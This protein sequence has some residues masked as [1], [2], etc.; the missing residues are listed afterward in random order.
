MGL[1]PLSKVKSA[2]EIVGIGEN[3][4]ALPGWT[5]EGGCRYAGASDRCFSDSV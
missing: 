5:A 4:R 1:P 2:W 3:L